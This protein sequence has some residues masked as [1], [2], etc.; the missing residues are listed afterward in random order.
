M[1]LG[2]DSPE[3]IGIIRISQIMGAFLYVQKIILAVRDA[4]FIIKKYKKPLFRI[5]I[6][7]V[8]LHLR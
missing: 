4:Y 1:T 5:A 8:E 2:L 7:L 6:V 3:L